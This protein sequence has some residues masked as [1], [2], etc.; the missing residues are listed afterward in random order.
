MLLLRQKSWSPL[1]KFALVKQS[2]TPTPTLVCSLLCLLFGKL[3]SQEGPFEF[4]W[5]V[6]F[7]DHSREHREICCPYNPDILEVKVIHLV[8]QY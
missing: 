5:L 3:R 4:F 1:I 8:S 7:L 2:K 6:I